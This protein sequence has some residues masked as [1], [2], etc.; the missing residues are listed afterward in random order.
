MLKSVQVTVPPGRSATRVASVIKC[1]R[2]RWLA[3]SDRPATRRHGWATLVL[4]RTCRYDRDAHLYAPSCNHLVHPYL[5]IQLLVHSISR[6]RACV[7]TVAPIGVR[8]RFLRFRVATSRP[9]AYVQFA[10]DRTVI[11]I[12]LRLPVR[13]ALVLLLSFVIS[14]SRTASRRSCR[15]AVRRRIVGRCRVWAQVLEYCGSLHGTHHSPVV[16]AVVLCCTTIGIRW[17]NFQEFLSSA[18]GLKAA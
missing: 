7:P 6:N 18:S 3:S 17:V 1:A 13:C 2:S 8:S 14:S 15:L 4:S 12:E 10:A 5:H 11:P 9:C 16:S